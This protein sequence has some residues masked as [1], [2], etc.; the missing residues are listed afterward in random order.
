MKRCLDH[1]CSKIEISSFHYF[2]TLM[3]LYTCSVANPESDDFLKS[4][5]KPFKSASVL[6]VGLDLF[7]SASHGCLFFVLF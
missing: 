6:Y 2:L 4:F 3:K 7:I 1:K 5:N